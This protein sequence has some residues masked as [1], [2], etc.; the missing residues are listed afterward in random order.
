[1]LPLAVT[2]KEAPAFVGVI[3]DGLATQFAGASDPQLSAT[4][5]PYPFTAVS[6][7]LKTAE[8]FTCV[9]SEGFAIARV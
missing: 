7:P 1:M 9:V 8:V 6:V 5:L 3:L 4:A 2:V